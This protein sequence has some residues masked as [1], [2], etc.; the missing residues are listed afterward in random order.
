MGDYRGKGDCLRLLLMSQPNLA[1]G[2]QV[3][4]SVVLPP[5]LPPL[6]M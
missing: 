3:C 4:F 2:G 1:P 5:V 6:I